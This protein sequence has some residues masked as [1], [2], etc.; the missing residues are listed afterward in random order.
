[1]AQ[2][3][4]KHTDERSAKDA[5]SPAVETNWSAVA[6]EISAKSA[7]KSAPIG[8]KELQ[9]RA[10]SALST[11]ESTPESLTES[12]LQPWSAR[13]QLAFFFAAGTLC[14]MLILVPAFLL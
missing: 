5:D 13:R 14:W 8:A 10:A 3:N 12:V 11:P 7:P 2:S 1:M 9:D 4:L 6:T